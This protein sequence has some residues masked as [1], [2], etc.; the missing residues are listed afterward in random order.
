MPPSTSSRPSISTGANT[1]GAD[2]L[3]RI[4]AV[5]SPRSSTTALAGLE[6]GR[7]RAERRRQL[8]E[9][10]DRRRPASFRTRR[11]CVSLWPW[12][13]PRGTRK[14]PPLTPSGKRTRNS[15]S[16]CLRRK[17]SVCARRA[18]AERLAPV[19]A[20][21]QLLDLRGGHARRRTARRPPRPCW[22]RRSRPPG[23][24]VPRA[25]SARR[26]ARD[27]ARRRRTARGRCAA[28][29]GGL[30]AAIPVAAGHRRPHRQRRQQR[31][32]AAGGCEKSDHRQASF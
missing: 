18:V 21:M 14:S 29:G 7:D 3:A 26:R 22:C 11:I 24:A 10:L 12:I 13:R 23:R 8:V 15:R 16:S 5:R 31:R 6:V 25:P 4:A 27:R 32:G 1:P 2:M 17:L 28:V 20:R 19:G 9:I 30:R